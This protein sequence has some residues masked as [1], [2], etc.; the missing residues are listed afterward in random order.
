MIYKCQ[1]CCNDVT[2]IIGRRPTS[3]RTVLYEQND[4][5]QDDGKL[6]KRPDIRT[7]AHLIEDGDEEFE[8]R[9]QMEYE[10]ENN[11]LKRLNT[12]MYVQANSM[13]D[14]LINFIYS[15]FEGADLDWEHGDPYPGIKISFL[16][17]LGL[18]RSD[19]DVTNRGGHG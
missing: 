14:M 13:M 2:G 10:F 3:D 12:D 5:M 19:C 15:N 16:R 8:S 11:R 6:K 9:T 1:Q 7:L 18:Q 4:I 17:M